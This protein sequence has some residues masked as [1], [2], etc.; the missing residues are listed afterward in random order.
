[1]PEGSR[2]TTSDR[3]AAYY[4]YLFSFPSLATMLAV[5][6]LVTLFGGALAQ[7]MLGGWQG[8]LLGL[9]TSFLVFTSSTI[10]SALLTRAYLAREPIFTLRRCIVLS[11][12]VSVTWIFVF[13]VASLLNHM[14][15]ATMDL[16]ESL[17]IGSIV[18]SALRS[19]IILSLSGSGVSKALILSLLQP[20]L[21]VVTYWATMSF[22][23]DRL[24]WGLLLNLGMFA[25]SWTTLRSIESWPH[26]WASPTVVPLFRDFLLAW[27]EGVRE[28]LEGH[29]EV[30]GVDADL[31]VGWL[32]FKGASG[33]VS[34][35]L[36]SGIHPGP[37][38]DLGSSAL[39]QFLCERLETSSVGSFVFL[40]GISNHEHDL[41][42]HGQ[43]SLIAEEIA[44]SLSGGSEMRMASPVVSIQRRSATATSQIIGTVA[45]VTLTLS[46]KSFEDLPR[47]LEETII[48]KA[49]DLG[50]TAYIVDLHN[51]IDGSHGL[52]GQDIQDLCD[53]AVEAMNQTASLPRASLEVGCSRIRPT[54]FMIEDGM[55][56]MGIAAMAIY[57][58]GQS[59]VLLVVDGNNMIT[60]LREH[61]IATVETM[62]FD[63]V[64][65]GTTDTHVVNGLRT[66][67]RGYYPFGEKISWESI[68][69]AVR[70]V[71]ASA[72]ASREPVTARGGLA[73][74][75][76][77][78][79]L[80]KDGLAF[81]EHSLESGINRFK[82][83]VLALWFPALAVS[84]AFVLFL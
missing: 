5:T 26:G 63:S 22:A 16:S 69:K 56:L 80:G 62:G 73:I 75:K 78:R 65:V 14:A 53:A 76:G 33:V 37:F 15:T 71:V 70:T 41:A 7:A 12:S 47:E 59:R 19:L 55:G 30:V 40:H 4:A 8:L 64:E 25:V 54:D 31:P 82:R 45:L 66:G 57:V 13:F 43:C 51:S 32:S 50:I 6:A 1:M 61:L 81:L 58:A 38:R 20:M 84:S 29:L 11:F 21:G 10:V 18:A 39:P 3:I 28:P 52:D 68:D 9:R 2:G 35:F 24:V 74:V 17:L 83:G 79:V 34:G 72:A 27:T 48:S 44:G 60:G 77:L 42:R 36:V 46:P 67:A 23:L 49:R